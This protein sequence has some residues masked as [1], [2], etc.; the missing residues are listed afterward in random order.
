QT[1]LIKELTIQTS[2][3]GYFVSGILI[4]LLPLI[5]VQPSPVREADQRIFKEFGLIIFATTFIF[6]ITPA[7]ERIIA[8][9]QRF[10][11]DYKVADMLPVLKIMVERWLKGE[12]IYE[13][14]HFWEGTE[15]IYLPAM[16]IP[17]IPTVFW[18]IDLRWTSI[19]ALLS[20]VVF[21]FCMGKKGRFNLK[22]L[23]TGIPLW[24]LLNS[25]LYQKSVLIYLSEE[26]VVIDYYLFLAYTLAKNRPY[27]IGIALSLCL[28][29]RFS[30][31][32]WFIMYLV[33]LFLLENRKMACKIAI[34]TGTICSVLLWSTE[35]LWQLE[36]ILNLPQIYLEHL[37]ENEWKFAGFA[38]TNLGLV[39]F[40]GFENIPTVHRLFFGLNLIIP[41]FSLLFFW[42]FKA[43]INRP[44]FAICS[45][46]LSLVFFYNF[47]IMPFSYLFYTST[48]LSLAILSWYLKED[49]L[50]T[51]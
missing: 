9:F 1:A 6:S 18:G 46:K 43:Q 2:S 17:Y 31:A 45:L 44:F 47:L 40:F 29:S 30:L 3:I 27:L 50:F 33:Y 16:W 41:T 42:K 11:V 24:L 8:L 38:T 14:V 25:I 36:V 37:M 5:K 35:A 15:P 4:A 20:S 48:F 21:L 23:L 12:R 49:Y 39:K 10:A 22:F 28:M 13:I 7:Y 32:F 26:P 19:V 34:T 51:G